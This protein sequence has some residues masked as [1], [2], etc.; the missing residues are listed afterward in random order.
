M[1]YFLCIQK[2]W[3][4][5]GYVLNYILKE[6]QTGTIT[7][8]SQDKVLQLL[9]DVNIDIINLRLTP[10]GTIMDCEP[11]KTIMK[12]LKDKETK[13][14]NDYISLIDNKLVMRQKSEIETKRR[15]EQELNNMLNQIRSWQPRIQKLIEILKHI[16]EKDTEIWEKF[17]GTYIGNAQIDGY[18]KEFWLRTDGFHHSTGGYYNI[19]E[20]KIYIGKRAGG[21]CGDVDFY[22]DGVIIHF[23]ESKGVN[24]FGLRGFVKEFEAYE[25]VFYTWLKE[26]YK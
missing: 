22:T 21:A 25:K 8:V 18:K 20:G 17:Q 2:N 14:T 16:E 7:T 3:D 5:N 10:K 6:I 11:K 4:A 12:K 19:K 13:Q 1:R 26:R 24:A 9:Y 23:N 15:E